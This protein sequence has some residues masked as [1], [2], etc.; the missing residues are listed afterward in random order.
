MQKQLKELIDLIEQYKE[1][2]KVK[3]GY[4][5]IPYTVI[6]IDQT[7]HNKIEEVKQLLEQ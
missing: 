7:M 6:R 4:D 2:G 1:Q 5:F 3:F